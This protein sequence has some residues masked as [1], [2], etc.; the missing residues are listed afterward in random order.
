MQFY[1]TK[2]LINHLVH[3]SI[4]YKAANFMRITKEIIYRDIHRLQLKIFKLL[5]KRDQDCNLSF[6]P[7]SILIQ[8]NYF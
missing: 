8:N 2:N 4:I 6:F 7:L 5:T 1:A 3:R